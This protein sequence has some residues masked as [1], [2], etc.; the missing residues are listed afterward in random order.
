[1]V[2]LI[3]KFGSSLPFVGSFLSMI[4]L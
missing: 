2:G 4:G 1:L 3:T